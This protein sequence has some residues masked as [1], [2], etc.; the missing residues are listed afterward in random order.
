MATDSFNHLQLEETWTNIGLY[1]INNTVLVTAMELFIDLSNKT[2][3]DGSGE[4][5]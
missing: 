2:I 1:L 5:M 3:Y 4:M